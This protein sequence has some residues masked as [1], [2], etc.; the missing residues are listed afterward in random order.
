MR[1]DDMRTSKRKWMR[2]G[3]FLIF[4]ALAV[5]VVGFLTAAL[6]NWLVPEIFSWKTITFGQALGLLI[7]ARILFGGFRGHP[8]WGGRRRYWRH[9][10]AERWERMTPEERESFRAGMRARCGGFEAPQSEPQPSP[11]TA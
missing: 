4:A 1:Y 2:A 10:M 8:G 11:P 6:W 9:R 3:A 7:L 5:V